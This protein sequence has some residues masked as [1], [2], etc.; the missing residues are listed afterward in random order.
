[1]TSLER[2]ARVATV[3][4]KR[5]GCVYAVH[6]A[7]QMCDECM[8]MARH[9]AVASSGICSACPNIVSASSGWC[10]AADLD[11]AVSKA[12][13]ALASS[14]RMHVN[15]SAAVGYEYREQCRVALRALAG[16]VLDERRI[17]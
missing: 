3:E 2:L 10:E 8:G 12:S 13:R 14:I 7:W 16:E 5:D 17:G 9:V 15:D 4:I 6:A 11:G 1:M